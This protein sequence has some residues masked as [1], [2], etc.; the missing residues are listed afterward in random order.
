MSK[1]HKIK[2]VWPNFENTTHRCI[3]KPDIVAEKEVP[4]VSTLPEMTFRKLSLDV[5][6]LF[7]ELK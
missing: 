7:P 3:F 6:K 2:K 5:S 4:S 1:K